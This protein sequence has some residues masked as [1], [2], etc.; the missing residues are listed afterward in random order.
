MEHANEKL[1]G[2][3]YKVIADL[4]LLLTKDDFVKYFEEVVDFIK[5]IETKNHSEFEMMKS[6]FASLAEKLKSDNSG[7]NEKMMGYCK[8]EMAEMY[9][10]HEKMMEMMDEKMMM[11]R[12]G[13]DGKDADEEMIMEKVLARIKLPEPILETTEMLRDRLEGLKGNERLDMNAISG[14]KEALAETRPRV[15]LFGGTPRP[16]MVTETP[17]GTINGVNAAFTITATPMIGYMLFLNGQLQREGS[18]YEYTIANKTITYNTAPLVGSE[19]Y[20]IIFK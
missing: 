11:M 17:S 1:K 20:I 5:R 9:K 16:R 6:H 8:K 7:N 19:H 10:E 2:I 12:D 4:E 3:Q 14:L 13:Q 15:G 18:S